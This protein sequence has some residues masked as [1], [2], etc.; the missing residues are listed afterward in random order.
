MQDSY[1]DTSQEDLS[2]LEG[3]GVLFFYCKKKN[4]LVVAD[5]PRRSCTQ[6]TK[7]E[8]SEFGVC[9]RL[10][11]QLFY[12]GALESVLVELRGREI[13]SVNPA[14]DCAFSAYPSGVIVSDEL[15]LLYCFGLF[16]LDLDI[17]SWVVLR[18]FSTINK[19]YSM[20][21]RGDKLLLTGDNERSVYLYDPET[22]SMRNVMHRLSSGCFKILLEAED[23][24]V[25]LYLQE[26]WVSKESG[27]GWTR[28][29][30]FK[31]T[32]H[33]PITSPVT[34][35]NLIYFISNDKRLWQINTTEYSVSRF[36]LKF[37]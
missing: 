7:G 21:R 18:K 19:C 5:I 23:K 15:Y 22:D 36:S 25:L 37:R 1:L 29:G 4:G 28:C 12:G 27:K 24:A 8:M 34:M 11:R 35:S 2:F 26:I 13:K 6:F 17:N 31:Y 16:K 32:L 9:L 3:E 20:A 10:G 30:S 33:P 14:Y